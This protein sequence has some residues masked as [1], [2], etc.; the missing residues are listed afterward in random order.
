MLNLDG[1]RTNAGKLEVDL[2]LHLSSTPSL[3]PALYLQVIRAARAVGIGKAALPDFLGWADPT[4]DVGLLGQDEI[5]S[6][7][8]DIAIREAASRLSVLRGRLGLTEKETERLVETR[9]RLGQDRFAREVLGSYAHRCGFCG[10][11]VASLP[12]SRLLHASHIKPWR[13]STPRER[14]DPRNGIA[15]CPTHDAAFDGGLLMVNGGWRIHRAGSLKR[16]VVREKPAERFFGKGGVGETLVLPE[17][18]AGPD[19]CY[20]DYHREHVFRGN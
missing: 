18:S 8:I 12:R 10:L 2:Y 14:L 6:V 15:A 7:E 3:Y 4:S 17:G 13:D 11:S 20:L 9:V 5:G 19:R 16:L 1:S